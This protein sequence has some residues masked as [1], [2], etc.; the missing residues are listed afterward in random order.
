[1]TS[2]EV[3]AWDAVAA[4]LDYPQDESYVARVAASV[5]EL[6]ALGLASAARLAVLRDAI[7]GRTLAGL[8][9]E[10]AAAFDF[11][12]ESALEM[13]WHLFG[14][15]PDRGPWLAVLAEALERA[16]VPRRQEL[17]DHLSH[18]LML[19]AREEAPHATTLAELIAPALQKV[20][21]RLTERGSPFAALIDTAACMLDG[22][23][24][25]MRVGP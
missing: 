22:C 7:S 3:A 14:D 12:P 16:G 18:L 21:K 8:Q 25:K 4:L 24:E 23:V 20:H 10:Y 6:D 17:P 5:A 9:E 15:G 1:M 11:D 2:A 13:G 19:I